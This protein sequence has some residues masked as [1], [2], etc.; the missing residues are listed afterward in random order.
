[1]VVNSRDLLTSTYYLVSGSHFVYAVASFVEKSL[2]DDSVKGQYA[3]QIGLQEYL[4]M[5]QT[6]QASTEEK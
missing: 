2:M 6:T 1:M 3:T 4:E 5:T